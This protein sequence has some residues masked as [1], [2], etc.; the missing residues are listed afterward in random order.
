MGHRY[1]ESKTVLKMKAAMQVK[2]QHATSLE[3]S[4]A[5][6]PLNI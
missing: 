2:K 1:T 6:H 3:T 4:K 5:S